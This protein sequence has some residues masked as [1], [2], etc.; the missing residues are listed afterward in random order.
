M[1]DCDATFQRAAPEY[2]KALKESGYQHKMEYEP[3]LLN[4][5]KKNPR[6]RKITWY[7]PPFN[8]GVKTNIGRIFLNLV[9]KHFPKG[10]TLHKLFNKNNVKVSY[11]CSRNMGSIIK[12]HNNQLLATKQQEQKK[13]CNCRK[14][15]ECPL[16]GNCLASSII[17]KATVTTNDDDGKHYIGLTD[18]TFKTRYT[19]HKHTFNTSKH[20]NSTELS[21]YIWKLKDNNVHYNIKWSIIDRA[22]SYSTKTKRCNL[23]STEKLHIIYSDKQSILNKRTELLSKCRHSN[24]FLIEN[25]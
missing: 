8:K 9:K 21:K 14:K 5:T 20:R 22:L 6:N 18:T 23:C 3:P 12:A 24:K 10:C 4:D 15:H 17:Y 16:S 25:T 11:S 13:S 7:N 19:N 1:C 2:E